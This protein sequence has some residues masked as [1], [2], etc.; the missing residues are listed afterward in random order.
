MVE[1]ML[2]A[3]R[4]GQHSVGIALLEVEG[5]YLSKTHSAPMLGPYTFQVQ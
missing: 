4:V 2:N 3:L 1:Q 5:V